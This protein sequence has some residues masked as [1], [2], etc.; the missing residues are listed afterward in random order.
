MVLLQET[1]NLFTHPV[2]A[3][4]ADERSVQARTPEG[5]EAVEHRTT[6]HRTDGLIILEN[7][8][9]NRLA[10]TYY[11]THCFMICGCKD[12]NKLRIKN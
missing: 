3:R 9:E 6:R 11:L 12:T 4:L 7:D 2:V 5:D 10:Y 1:D 8:V